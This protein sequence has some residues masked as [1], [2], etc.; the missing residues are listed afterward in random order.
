MRFSTVEEMLAPFAIQMPAVG[1]S[2]IPA[3]P[4]TLRRILPAV[5]PSHLPTNHEHARRE[6]YLTAVGPSQVLD[7]VTGQAM[8]GQ[9]HTSD[10]SIPN[11]NERPV[12]SAWPIWDATLEALFPGLG[13]PVPGLAPHATLGESSYM[14]QSGPGDNRVHSPYHE[15]QDLEEWYDQEEDDGEDEMEEDEVDDD[16]DDYDSVNRFQRDENDNYWW[17][18]AQEEEDG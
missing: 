12:E 3:Q 16:D 7:P 10:L 15:S 17:D 6:E 18:D 1:P 14:M 9:G 2:Q 11:R 13:P 5:A 8:T 4:A